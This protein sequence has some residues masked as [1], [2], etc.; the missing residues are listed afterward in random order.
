MITG[1][2]MPFRP[3]SPDADAAMY[4][5]KLTPSVTVPAVIKI[6]LADE[7]TVVSGK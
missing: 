6:G 3:K 4:F 2:V 7:R 1:R 5:E